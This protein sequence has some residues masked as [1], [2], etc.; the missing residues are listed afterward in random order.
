MPAFAAG[1]HGLALP[2]A[3]RAAAGSA[4]TVLARHCGTSSVPL[5]QALRATTAAPS[6]FAGLEIRG[7]GGWEDEEARLGVR[8]CCLEIMAE[9]WRRLVEFFLSSARI[10]RLSQ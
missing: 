2:A 4:S 9:G 1:G 7:I 10:L 8:S 3:L 5:W 6:Y